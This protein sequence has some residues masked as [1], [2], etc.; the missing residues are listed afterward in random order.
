VGG[1]TTV[2][3]DRILVDVVVAG[4]VGRACLV[5]REGARPGDQLFVSG[6]LG[7]SALGLHRLKT[8]A[9]ARGTRGPKQ[10]PLPADAALRAHSYP[11]PR[12]AWGQR[13]G[14]AHLASAMIDVSDGLSTDLRHLCEASGVG[15]EV[16]AERLPVPRGLTSEE[17]R[18]LDPLQLALNGGE[19]YEL[20]FT[21]PRRKMTHVARAAASVPVR[22]IGEITHE[23][24][25]T[26]VH[27]DGERR[28]LKPGGYDHFKRMTN[29]H[30]F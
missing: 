5:K 17:R 11:Q 1:D 16:W 19:D 25:I 6:R 15:A 27:S 26:I 24:R 7:M 14:K 9:G 23:N 20:L 22:W 29:P 28:E 30:G 3:T 2:G 12:L 21:V 4:E 8:W 13:L 18:T 10:R